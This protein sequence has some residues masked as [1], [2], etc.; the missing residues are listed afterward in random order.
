MDDKER[1]TGDT[2][3]TAG[4]IERENEHLGMTR[5]WPFDNGLMS[6]KE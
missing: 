3:N 1:V 6:R 4:D 5:A 2:F